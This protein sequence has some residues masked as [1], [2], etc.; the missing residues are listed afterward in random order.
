MGDGAVDVAEE[1]GQSRPVDGILAGS[2]R[3]ASSSTTTIE[4]RVASPLAAAWRAVQ[5][6]LGVPQAGLDALG[7]ASHEDGPG[8]AVAQH[9]PCPDQ[10]VGERLQPPTEGRLLPVAG[11][12]RHREL[13]EVRGS[14]EVLA[15]HRVADRLGA[16]AVLLV[17]LGR[18]P[19]ELRDVLG[20]LI[21]QAR[22]EHV[23]EQMVVAIPLPPVV[24]GDEE[25][26]PPLERLEHRLAAVLAGDGVG[27]AGH[28]AG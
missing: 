20:P 15:G 24:Q 22:L 6:A 12:R 2:V 3:N 23:G 14:R 9:G 5:P 27:T 16:F 18:A 28:S 25:Q 10:L 1:P 11:R 19:M 7:L 21:A 4:A 26:V 13:D 17:P 8:V